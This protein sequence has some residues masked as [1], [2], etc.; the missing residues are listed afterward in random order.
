M[1]M[2][3]GET[4]QV[5]LRSGRSPFLTTAR[6]WAEVVAPPIT[7]M[8]A[9]YTLCWMGE[10]KTCAQRSMRSLARALVL[11]SKRRWSAPTAGNSV[12]GEIAE[13]KLHVRSVWER[14]AE[15]A[16]P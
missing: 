2:V 8:D 15:M 4:T 9:R 7:A 16:K 12:S 3:S 13:Y 6:T 5:I 11:P 14:G 1:T 10:M